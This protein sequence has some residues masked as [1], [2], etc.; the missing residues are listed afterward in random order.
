MTHLPIGLALS[1]GTAKSVAHVGVLRALIENGITA[2]Y[3]AGTSGGSLI[4]ALYAAGKSIDDLET[5]AH[6]I[7]WGRIAKLTLPKLGLLSG[8]R[9]RRFIVEEIGDVEFSDLSIPL[10][11]VAAD[12][13]AGKTR[14]F[15]EGKVAIACQASSSIPSF[16]APVELDGDILV[17]GGIAEYVPVSA[18]VSL[19]DM[20]AIGVNLGFEP[21]SKKPRNLIEIVSRVTNF[22]EQQ[23]AILSE[24]AADFMIRPDLSEF[25]PLDLRHPSDIM[26]KAYRETIDVV[27]G[28]LAAIGAARARRDGEP[29][30]SL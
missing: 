2:D 4:A 7:R 11:V 17:D 23:N 24:R 12:L 22:M 14:V 10:A 19:G 27:P 30:K 21:A 20:F 1:G 18:L 3:L 29:K 5:L 28:L 6:G 13:T 8:D 26:T 9:L 16:Y 15:T 25:N